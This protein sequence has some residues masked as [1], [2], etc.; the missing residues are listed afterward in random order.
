MSY[1]EA[2]KWYKSKTLWAN[3]IVAILAAMS[4]LAAA[5][6]FEEYAQIL[7]V[8]TAILNIGLRIITTQPLTVGDENDLG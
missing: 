2:K 8:L 4:E 5:P 6:S 7:L 3:L 1:T